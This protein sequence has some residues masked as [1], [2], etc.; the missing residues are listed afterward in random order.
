MRSGN[1]KMEI[2]TIALHADRD[3]SSN[4]AVAPALE[5]SVTYAVDKED[6]FAA[7]AEMPFYDQF[8]A[9]HGT[10][11]SSKIAKVIADM[12]GGDGA[13]MF[14]SGM[15]AITTTI[16]SFVN[17][18]DHI[19]VQQSLYSATA[20]FFRK[21]LARFGVRVS[22]VNQT[23]IETFEAEITNDTKLIYVETPVNPL[24]TLTDLVKIS[25]IA[26]AHDILTIC[27][28]TFATPVNQKPLQLGIDVVVHSVTK[29]IGG[30][31]DLLSGC[32][33]TASSR[34]EQIWDTGMDLGPTAAPF[35]SW[36]ALRGVRTLKLRVDQQNKNALQIATFLENHPC[37][38]KIYYPGLKSHLQHEL[39]KKQMSG[40]GG[41]IAFEV[42]GGYEKAAQFINSL[43]YCLNAAS[44]G[45]VDTLVI[46]PASMFRARLDDKEIQA[47]G[48]APGLV[49]LSIGIEA[50][51]D[52]IE[53]LD[54]A[55]RSK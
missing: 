6:D 43:K 4:K 7:K 16:L 14:S 26:K 39:A 21:F 2:E 38:G 22:A 20:S 1:K 44:L 41:M 8:Y 18:G 15:A 5:Q 36:L 13:L 37:V 32:V 31:H 49:R 23:S 48:I 30:H 9:R 27:D 29:Y 34:L 28:N 19:I 47:L 45:G 50:V 24:M 51:T 35:N 11:T 46:Q 52:L 53:D 40:S 17:A 55:L 25:E 10:P 3:L 33:V 12:E 54:Q 42:L